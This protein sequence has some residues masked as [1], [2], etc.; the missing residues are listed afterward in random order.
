ML[1]AAPA[2]SSASGPRSTSAGSGNARSANAKKEARNV[3]GEFTKGGQGQ[4]TAGKGSKPAPKGKGVKGVPLPKSV[5]ASAHAA[6]VQH[7]KHVLLTS[8]ASDRQKAHELIAKRDLLQ[9]ELASASGQVNKGQSGSTT[10]SQ[11]GSTTAS[12]APAP[13]TAATG[14]TNPAGTSSSLTQAPGSTSSLNTTAS[15]NQLRTQIQALNKQ[16]QQYLTAAATAIAQAK[17]LK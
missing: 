4:A 1:L 10:G 16:I 12:S 3:A 17:A 14:A 13:A 5:P 11:A 9:K 2:T 15:Q 8:A 6:H 7:Q